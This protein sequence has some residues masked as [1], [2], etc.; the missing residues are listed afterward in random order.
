MKLK[1]LLNKHN[2]MEK[3]ENINKTIASKTVDDFNVLD[4]YKN[5]ILD[6]RIIVSGVAESVRK[7]NGER[8]KEGK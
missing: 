8:G 4:I 5:E 2:N 1:L 6:T 7:G 3:W